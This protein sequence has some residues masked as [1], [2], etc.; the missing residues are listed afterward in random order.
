MNGWKSIVA[1]VGTILTGL[2]MIAA[3]LAKEGGFALEN[4]TTG[5]QTVLA[6]LAVLGIAHKIEKS[7][8]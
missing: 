5:M 2:G 3:G 4:I 1:G 7:G 8:Q 6:G